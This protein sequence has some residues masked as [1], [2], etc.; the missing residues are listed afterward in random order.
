MTPDEF[1]G[2]L[3]TLSDT[4]YDLLIEE[5]IS[6]LNVEQQIIAY[7]RENK[8]KEMHKLF[9]KLEEENLLEEERAKILLSFGSF[10]QSN[11]EHGRSYCKNCIACAEIDHIMLPEVYNENGDRINEG[12]GT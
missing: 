12:D 5:R 11:C 8:R 9:L 2:Y 4:E 7:A 10:S 3:V 1:E 6:R